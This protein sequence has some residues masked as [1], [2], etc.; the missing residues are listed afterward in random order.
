MRHTSSTCDCHSVIKLLNI[1]IIPNGPSDTQSP[2][3]DTFMF[4]G[5]AG[6][7]AGL[8]T[9]QSNLHFAMKCATGK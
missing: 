9:K 1:P 3:L 4:V 5:K 8:P 7:N 6:K 2:L